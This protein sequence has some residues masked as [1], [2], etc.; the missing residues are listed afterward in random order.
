MDFE[1]VEIKERTNSII[2]EL[3]ELWEK[4]VR[5]THLFLSVDEVQKIKQYVPQALKEIAVLTAAVDNSGNFLGFMGTA[6][7]KLEM[8]FLAP[9]QI[10]KDLGGWICCDGRDPCRCKVAFGK[11]NSPK[12]RYVLLI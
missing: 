2:N 7:G 4:S 3:T 8:L 12:Y 11:G 5:A 9:E 10:G 6:N 1:I